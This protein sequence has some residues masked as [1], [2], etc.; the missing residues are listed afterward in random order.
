MLQNYNKIFFSLVI[1]IVFYIL[2]ITIP[3]NE[4]IRT[5]SENDNTEINKIHFTIKN[6]TGLALG[7]RLIPIS[8]RARLLSMVH[9]LM[10]F[11]LLLY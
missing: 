6:H 1:L 10:S 9:G 5:N 3:D 2:Y 11:F 4:F 7:N 8:T